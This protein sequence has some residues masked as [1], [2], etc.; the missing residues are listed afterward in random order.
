MFILCIPQTLA[1]TQSIPSSPQ[2]CPRS[3]TQDPRLRMW[4]AR[5]H[6]I[7]MPLHRGVSLSP[8][9]TLQQILILAAQQ[10]TSINE[11]SQA[12]APMLA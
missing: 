1:V 5:L 9:E 12:G 10:V 6:S 3:Q 11:S 2:V 8:G 7:L 4:C